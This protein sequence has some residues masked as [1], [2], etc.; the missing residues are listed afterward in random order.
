MRGV[1]QIVRSGLAATVLAL[2]IG[3]ALPGEA[4]ADT[5]NQEI[6][7][8]GQALDFVDSLAAQAFEV[9]KDSK[10]STQER[11]ERARSLIQRGFNVRYMALMALGP[12]ARD[13]DNEMLADYEQK[14]GDFLY[15]KYA[16]LVEA[17]GV[18]GFQ[19]MEAERAGLRDV[20]VHMMVE[21]GGRTIDIDWRVR[22]FDSEPRVIDILVSG[23]SLT[24]SE[25]E[26]FA[27]L[28][29]ESG[30]KGLMNTLG[31]Y[32]TRKRA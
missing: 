6:A 9:L 19:T 24:Q 8:I 17:A 5:P 31:S 14:F 2:T 27:A 13:M 1:G 25:R 30:F 4:R 28:I 3:A 11:T 26:E 15:G 23:L 7:D 18:K 29:K 10:L 12:Y 32:S 22:M 21:E 20:V 16:G